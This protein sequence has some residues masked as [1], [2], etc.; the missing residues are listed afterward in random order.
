MQRNER[1]IVSASIEF[2]RAARPSLQRNATHVLAALALLMSLASCGMLNSKRGDEPAA[3]RTSAAT[4]EHSTPV[5]YS[6][7][8]SKHVAF[9]QTGTA[10]WYGRELHGRK[11]A[12]GD[13]FDMNGMTAA[14]RTLPLS[15]HVRVTNLEN[16]RTVV[17]RVNDRGPFVGDRIID[18]SAA[19]ATRLGF[20][21]RGVAKVKVEAV[22]PPTEAAGTLRHT[23]T[24]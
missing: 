16:G 24:R 9:T 13:I 17:L 12:S 18:V 20:A 3:S 5:R 14:H 8:E 11:T 2:H 21:N 23:A 1:K 22:L 15:S 7:S 6:R 19:A 10:S 4:P